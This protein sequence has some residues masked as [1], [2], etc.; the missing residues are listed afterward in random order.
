MIAEAVRRSALA[1]Y[2]ERFAALTAAS[3]RE[4]SIRELPFVSQ[5]NLRA[6]PNNAD[7]MHRLA[8]ALGFPLP[9]VPNDVASREERRALWLGPD[10]WLVVGPDGQQETLEQAL[11]TGL[12]GAFGSIVDVSANRT[13]LE[14]SGVWA[15]EFLARGVPIDLDARSFGPNR[16]AQTLLGKAQAI[17]ERRVE[18][19]FHLYP[20]T[21]F[22]GY[23]ADWLLDAAAE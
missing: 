15:R 19:A 21:S 18:S 9:V 4:L 17:I 5:V 22:A 14:I 20:R 6:D 2:T 7:L 10:E 11:R 23:V 8:A 3:G 1:H 12:D 13:V 16:C